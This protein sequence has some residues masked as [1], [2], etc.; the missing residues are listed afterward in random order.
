VLVR[1]HPWLLIL[2]SE[3]TMRRTL[4]LSILGIGLLTL[5]NSASNPAAEARWITDY[6][7]ARATAKRL[8]RPIFLVFR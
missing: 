2:E 6:E 5:T 4:P 1:V 3:K 8:G 7:E